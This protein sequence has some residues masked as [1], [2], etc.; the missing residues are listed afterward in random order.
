MAIPHLASQEVGDPQ[1][2]SRNRFFWSRRCNIVQI[3]PRGVQI[4]YRELWKANFPA[5]N[6]T[7]FKN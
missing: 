5:N 3:Q 7:S 6:K 1:E 2:N 4:E